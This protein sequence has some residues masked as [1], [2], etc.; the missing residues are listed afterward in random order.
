MAGGS[1]EGAVGGHW[2]K[3]CGR[4]LVKASGIVLYTHPWGPFH[5][6]THKEKMSAV[7]PQSFPN[8]TPLV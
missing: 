4:I 2:V 8:G 7:S 6:F 3:Q 5:V 1:E